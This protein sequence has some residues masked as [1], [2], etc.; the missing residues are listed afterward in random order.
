M[1]IDPMD[2]EMPERKNDEIER[3]LKLLTSCLE[4]VNAMLGKKMQE[5]LLRREEDSL[6][7]SQ[8]PCDEY[9][10]M[11]YDEDFKFDWL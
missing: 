1:T 2:E 6:R 5:D 7:E 10:M 9:D 3:S 11:F 8:Y 4:M